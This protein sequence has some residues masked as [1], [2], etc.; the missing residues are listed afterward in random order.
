MV[1]AIALLEVSQ[2]KIHSIGEKLAEMANV[3]EV[4]SVAGR[5]DL[6]VIARATD[7]DAL[8]ELFTGHMLKLEGVQ[9]SETLVAVKVYSRHDLEAMFSIGMDE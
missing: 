6:V 8:E 1:T 9:K 4:Y 3:S 7:N 2:D 5:C